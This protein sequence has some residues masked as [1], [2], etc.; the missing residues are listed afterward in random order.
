MTATAVAFA[1]ATSRG[2]EMGAAHIK[3]GTG[4]PETTEYVQRVCG[5]YGWPLKVYEPPVPYEQIVVEYGFPGPGQ[6]GLMYRR[7]KERAL[8]QLVREHKEEVRDRVMLVTGVRSEES[9]R[10]MRHVERVQR[11]GAQVWAANIWN[12]SK[13]DCNRLIAERGLARNPVVDLL[14]MSGECLCGAFAR[15]GEIEEIEQWFPKHAEWL[16]ELEEKVRARGLAGCVWGKRPPRVHA[17]QMS[18]LLDDYEGA[19]VGPLCVGC[20]PDE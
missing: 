13:L 9:V 18:M 7:L 11:E 10:R 2:V 14:H 17:E 20:G 5:E 8:R 16:H 12:W 15:P 6:H 4:I 3:T 19:E 1:W